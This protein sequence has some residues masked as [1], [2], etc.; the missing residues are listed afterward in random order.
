MPCIL[1]LLA[2][3]NAKQARGGGVFPPNRIGKLRR[4]PCAFI[5]KQE[6]RKVLSLDKHAQHLRAPRGGGNMQRRFHL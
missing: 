2:L 5:P 1:R 3:L 6:S 4:K